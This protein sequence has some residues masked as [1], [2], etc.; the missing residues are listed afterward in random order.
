MIIESSA[1][2]LQA[3]HR[4]YESHEVQ[5]SVF[6]RL[7]RQQVSEGFAPSRGSSDAD[8]LELSG[9]S[10]SEMKGKASQTEISLEDESML[11]GIKERITALIL[12]KVLGASVKLLKVEN[13]EAPEASETAAREV[14]APQRSGFSLSYDRI[15]RHEEYEQTV[16]TAEGQVTTADGRRIAFN[17][18][19]GM[20]RHEVQEA[21]VSLRMGEAEKVDPLVINFS[22]QPAALV[23]ESME[24]DLDADGESESIARLASHSGY[25]AYDRNGDGLVN[26]GSELFGPT[27]GHGF[28]ELASYDGDGNGWI[29]EADAIYGQLSIWVQDGREG[30]L[31]LKDADVGAIHLGSVSTPF[32]LNGQDGESLGEIAESGVYLHEDGQVGSIQEV[33]LSV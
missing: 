3:S 28:G 7:G 33:D 29:D 16:M 6:I 19:L 5:E 11:S 30:L 15:E 27:T 14:A 10:A 2:R 22:A 32:E 4:E 23:Q 24:F 20:E 17:L 1:V 21:R 25:L 12:K 26:D 31:S 18:N 8:V 9:L 13:A